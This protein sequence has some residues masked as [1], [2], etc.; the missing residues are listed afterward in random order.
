[1]N[2]AAI[3]S[4]EYPLTKKNPETKKQNLRRQH[5]DARLGEIAR[6]IN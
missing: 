4:R 3:I 2:R 6:C 5:H 1:M